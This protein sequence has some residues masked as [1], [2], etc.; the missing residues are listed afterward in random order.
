MTL[1][2]L[3]KYFTNLG[4]AIERFPDAPWKDALAHGQLQSKAWAATELAN[5]TSELG[6]A[7]IVAGW[8]GTLMPFLM[9]EPRL[10]IRKI[11]SFDIDPRCEPVADQLNIEYVIDDWRYKAI[12]KDMFEIDYQEHHYTIPGE[13][14]SAMMVE[15]PDII[16]NTSCDHIGDFRRW[17]RLIP[18]GKL[19]V[20]Q[21][22]NFRDGG[23][24]HINTVDSLEQLLAQAPMAAVAYSGCREFAQYRRFMVIGTK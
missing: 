2:E 16:I 3:A 15:S 11:R 21:N 9:A 14:G 13:N 8:L 22:N 19:V 4:R 6:M 10:T 12:T 18:S 1:V 17:W 20:L 5:I 24:D 7:Y 23:A